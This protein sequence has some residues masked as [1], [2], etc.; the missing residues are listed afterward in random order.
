PPASALLP[1]TTLF[2][3]LVRFRERGQA[4][5]GAAGTAAQRETAAAADD[6]PPQIEGSHTL[7]VI[8]TVIPFLLLIIMAI[9]TVRLNFALAAEDRKSTRLNSSH[10]KI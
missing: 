5:A 1:Y 7:E 2:R 9:P 4:A 8:W 3:S 6:L 10:V